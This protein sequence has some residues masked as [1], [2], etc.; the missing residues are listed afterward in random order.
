MR[1]IWQL[2]DAKSKLSE[3]I[4]QAL[5]QGVQI[6]TRRGKKTVVVMPFDEYERLTKHTDDL[7][8]FL[9]NSPLAGSELDVERDKSL[10]RKIDI[11]P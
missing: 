6:I 8:Q 3:M 7:A 5:S 1:N 4:D 9:L 11:E 10:P 2:Q